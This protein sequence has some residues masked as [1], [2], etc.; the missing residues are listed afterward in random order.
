MSVSDARGART[1]GFW[2][3]V[4]ASGHDLHVTVVTGAKPREGAGFKECSF[5]RL[6]GGRGRHSVPLDVSGRGSGGGT[7]EGGEEKGNRRREAPLI[8]SLKRME[9]VTRGWRW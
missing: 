7:T 4:P 1:P 8:L 9:E 5:Q 2:A 3:A 6:E